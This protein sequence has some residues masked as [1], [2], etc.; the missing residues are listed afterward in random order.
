VAGEEVNA[1]GVIEGFYGPPWTHAERLDLI[2]FC[3]R[4]GFNTWVHAPKDDRFHRERWRDPYPD[5]EVALFAELVD[6]AERHGV[7]FA[8]A[9]SPGLDICYSQEAEL[10]ALVEKCGQLRSIGVRSFQLLYDD[11]E[12]ELNCGADDERYGHEARPSAAAQADLSNR[13]LRALPQ[14][15]PLVV[16]PRGYAGTETTDYREVFGRLLDPE[17][18]VYWT[19][20][21]IVSTSITRADVDAATEG[22]GHELLLWDN[23]PVNDFA[24]DKLF[25]GPLRGREPGLG[26]AGL[27]A[28]GMLQAVPS[29][30]PL[31]TVADYLRDP[32][33]YDPTRSFER[34]LREYG[35]EVAAAVRALGPGVDVEDALAQLELSA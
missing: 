17:I 4:E 28:N 18:V 11:V 3:G 33:G 2:E 34:A 10:E 22:F 23:Y 27:I 13:F 30:L 16:C 9:I 12:Q 1:R 26:V 7:D 25:L 20:P 5:E 29:K 8:Y 15:G 32:D 19:G 24:P 6:A 14:D 31:A 21:E 35:E